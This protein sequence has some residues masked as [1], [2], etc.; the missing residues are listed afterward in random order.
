M[1][2]DVYVR[3]NLAQVQVGRLAVT[4]RAKPIDLPCGSERSKALATSATDKD[5]RWDRSGET[6]D[7]P[8]VQYIALFVEGAAGNILATCWLQASLCLLITCAEGA[9]HI[10]TLIAV[11]WFLGIG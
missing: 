1:C 2:R 4:V 9:L 3:T 7:R 6:R 8:L 10:I 5:S 11:F